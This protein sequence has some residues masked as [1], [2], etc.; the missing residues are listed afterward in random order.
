MNKELIAQT[1]Q[2]L[3][4]KSLDLVP[5]NYLQGL[6]RTAE[7]ISKKIKQLQ[8]Q[9]VSREEALSAYVGLASDWPLRLLLTKRL[10]DTNVSELQ[11]QAKRDKNEVHSLEVVTHCLGEQVALAKDLHHHLSLRSQELGAMQRAGSKRSAS[12]RWNDKIKKLTDNYEKTFVFL[13]E[14]LDK[15]ITDI[16]QSFHADTQPSAQRTLEGFVQRE[17]STSSEQMKEV[18]EALMNCSLEAN[19][20]YTIVADP[21]IRSFLLQSGLC[22]ADPNDASRLRLQE[23]AAEL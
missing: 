11:E 7:N 2:L 14:F 23:F 9:E 13:D 1:V 20:S 4:R 22:W 12:R 5:D 6:D 18:L 15:H 3:G 8:S 16:L 10:L 19:S 17:G 21:Q